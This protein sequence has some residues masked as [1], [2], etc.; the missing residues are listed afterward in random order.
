MGIF[1][2]VTLSLSKGSA[3]DELKVTVWAG[4]KSFVCNLLGQGF[5]QAL[6]VDLGARLLNRVLF[7]GFDEKCFFRNW[8]FPG[9]PE[10]RDVV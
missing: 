4:K 8:F 7:P 3:F 5:I 9:F 10:G 1:F 6:T 2:T